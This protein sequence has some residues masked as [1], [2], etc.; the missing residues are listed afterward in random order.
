MEFEFGLQGLLRV[1]ESFERKEE[2]KLAVAIGE[3]KRL[4]MMLARV[5]EELAS[6]GDRISSLLARGTTGAD[7]H[8]LCFEKMLLERRE[9]ALAQVVSTALKEVQQQQIRMQEA[10][11]KRKVLEDLRER[12]LALFLLAEGRK[13][14]QRLDDAFLMR[15]FA[16]DSGKGVA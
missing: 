1:R 9:Q 4:K 12:Q 15:R 10:R 14:Q 16:E 11:Q 8:L 6:I 2:L 3:L 7:L 13:D 5:R